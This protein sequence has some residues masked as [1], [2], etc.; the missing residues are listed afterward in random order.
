MGD[1]LYGAPGRGPRVPRLMLHACRL[2]LPHPLTGKRLVIESPHP[3][4]FGRALADVSS[5]ERTTRG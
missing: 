1:E 4:D 2:E 5:A 3:A